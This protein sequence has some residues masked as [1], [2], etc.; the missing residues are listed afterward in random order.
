MSTTSPSLSG[1]TGL[2]DLIMNH[3]KAA[4]VRAAAELKIPDALAQG[5]RTSSELAAELGFD[6]AALSRF[7]RACTVADIVRETEHEKFALTQTGMLLRSESPFYGAMVSFAA[8]RMN[9]MYEHVGETVRTGGP[10]TKA[11]LGEDFLDYFEDITTPATEGEPFGK[12]LAFLAG[13]AGRRLAARYDLSRFH[14]IVDVGGG[15]GAL[16]SSLLAAAPHA[17]GV[18]VD[19]P[20]VIERAKANV[21]G[22]PIADRLEFAPGSFFDGVPRGA[23][24]YTI[25]SVL[26][27]WDDEHAA[28]ILASIAAA[29]EPGTPLLVIDWLMPA[30]PASTPA[31]G[32]MFTTRMR[33]IDFWLL[34]T[35]GGKVRTEAEFRAMLDN[36]GFDVDNITRIETGPLSWDVIEARRR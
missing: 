23:D 30:E 32:D 20:E 9:R 27:D 12:A 34:L 6:R 14:R 24:L 16:I 28:R 5:P 13:P 7:L 18:L 36:A 26:L 3:E 33:L 15:H 4:Y 19:I 11:A 35:A 17:T 10:A 8:P 25:K 1:Y 22:K 21:A 31:E 29:A 2:I